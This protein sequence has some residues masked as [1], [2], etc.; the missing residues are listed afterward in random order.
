MSGG[1][2]DT[3]RAKLLAGAVEKPVLGVFVVVMLLMSVGFLVS[4]LLFVL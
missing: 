4:F 2:D 1:R 3:V